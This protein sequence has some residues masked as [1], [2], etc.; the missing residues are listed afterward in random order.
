M[1]LYT[2]DSNFNPYLLKRTEEIGDNCM[3]R[4]FK[5]VSFIVSF[6]V[7]PAHKSL[8]NQTNEQ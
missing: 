4:S 8:F 6:I 2:Q 5:I 3:V 7:S 1:T